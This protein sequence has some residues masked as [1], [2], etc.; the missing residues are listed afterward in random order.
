MRRRKRAT[1]LLDFFA[2][3]Y[4]THFT[5]IFL[6]TRHCIKRKQAKSKWMFFGTHFLGM[7]N[8]FH[9]YFRFFLFLILFLLCV[10]C[11]IIL[12]EMLNKGFRI[13]TCLFSL[14]REREV[15]QHYSDHVIELTWKCS[16][17]MAFVLHE[18][19]ATEPTPTARQFSNVRGLQFSRHTRNNDHHHPKE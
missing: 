12:F 5:L 16:F 13:Q 9:L 3:F 2:V 17:F 1:F 19:V 15:M 4:L 14:Q 7:K 10:F 11:K 8:V 6:L 18:E